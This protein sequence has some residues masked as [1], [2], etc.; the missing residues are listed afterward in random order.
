[1]IGGELI[2]GP[3]GIEVRP[4]SCETDHSCGFCLIRHHPRDQKGS[5]GLLHKIGSFRPKH[6]EKFAS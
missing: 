1:M 6:V 5:G 4:T 3:E 2:G